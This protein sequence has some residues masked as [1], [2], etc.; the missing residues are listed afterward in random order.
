MFRFSQMKKN[1]CVSRE[2][3][4]RNFSLKDFHYKLLSF[5]ITL[6]LIQLTLLQIEYFFHLLVS[7][8]KSLKIASVKY[9]RLEKTHIF[10]RINYLNLSCGTYSLQRIFSV[11]LIVQNFCKTPDRTNLT[12]YLKVILHRN[13]QC[14]IHFC[15]LFP[16][17]KNPKFKLQST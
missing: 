12:F 17:S 6:I 3:I 14:R 5:I 8:V 11:Y 9:F 10:S 4:F 15:N 7:Q 16:I 1:P 13:K 2:L